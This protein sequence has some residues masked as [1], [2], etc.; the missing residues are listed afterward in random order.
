MYVAREVLGMDITHDMFTQIGIGQSVSQ[1][2]LQPGDFVFF[3]NTFRDGL[4]HVGIYI[5]NGKFVHAENE[6]T[7]VVVSELHSDYYGSRW[8]GAARI[9]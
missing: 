5:G 1:D 8:Y 9:W 2:E 4:S 6:D 3:Q 7:G